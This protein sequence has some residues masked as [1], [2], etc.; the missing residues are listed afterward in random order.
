MVQASAP[1]PIAAASQTD[2]FRVSDSARTKPH[3]TIG[4]STYAAPTATMSDTTPIPASRAVRIDKPSE[5]WQQLI[6]T[7]PYGFTA[8][9]VPHGGAQPVYTPWRVPMFAW[10]KDVTPAGWRAFAAAYLGWLLDGFDFTMLTFVLVDIARSFTINSA[11]AGALGTVTLLFRLAGGIGAGAAA[12]KWGRKWPLALS[13]L[14]YSLFAFLSGFAPTY[15]VLFACRAL[16]GVGM[17]GVWTAGMP[18]AIEHWPPAL[19]GRVSGMLQSG[20]STGFMIAAFV[21]NVVAPRIDDYELRW[22]TMLWLGLLPSLLAFWTMRRV[23]ESPVW[24]ATRDQAAGTQ[25]G[26]ARLFRADLIATTLHASLVTATFLCF[27]YAVTFWYPT[28]LTQSGRASLPFLVLL[29]LGTM[30]GNVVWGQLSETGVGRRGA[31]TIATGGAVLATP[32]FIYGEQAWILLA[33]SFVVGMF[34]TGNFGVVPGYLAERFPT[35]TRALGAGFTYHVGAALASFM[36]LIIGAL[37]DDGLALGTAMAICMVASGVAIIV[38][39]WM[40]P[41]TRGRQL[42]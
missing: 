14:W 27:Y 23:E 19:R 18:L 20:F 28:L 33:A 26:F 15:A 9:P 5:S 4:S 11:L 30:L 24:L 39:I 42:N 16:F 13:I 36:P 1:D 38:S 41:E 35:A 17:G 3:A 8:D 31:A 40:G 7:T 34:G 6:S 29:N 10:R 12:D 37:V 22:R 2:P 25:H 32:L 21:V